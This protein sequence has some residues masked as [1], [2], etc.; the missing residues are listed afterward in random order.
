MAAN[1]NIESIRWAFLL[2]S[3]LTLAIIIY[4]IVV[5]NTLIKIWHAEFQYRREKILWFFFILLLSPIGMPLYLITNRKN[6]TKISDAEADVKVRP[7]KRVSEV[8]RRRAV[9]PDADA[10]RE[11]ARLLE[12]KKNGSLSTE[13]FDRAKKRLYVCGSEAGAKQRQETAGSR[14]SN[15]CFF[16]KVFNASILKK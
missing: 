9:M 6:K 15:R 5:I 2:S 11:L 3:L 12:L 16:D 10:A 8:F 1:P 7:A 14:L 4:V 13:E